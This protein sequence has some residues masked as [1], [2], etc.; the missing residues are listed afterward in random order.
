MPFKLFFFGHIYT[1]IHIY[2]QQ[3]RSHNSCSRM[4]VQGNKNECTLT[5]IIPQCFTLTTKR[6]VHF[7]AEGL[8]YPV[9]P[10]TRFLKKLREIVPFHRASYIILKYNIHSI[11]KIQYWLCTTKIQY[12]LFIFALTVYFPL[13]IA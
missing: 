1:Y 13:R 3:P 2:G 6:V 10:I 8:F 5:A 4:R 12:R 9:V 11:H 7:I